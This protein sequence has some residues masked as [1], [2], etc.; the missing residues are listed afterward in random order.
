MLVIIDLQD[1]YMPQFEKQRDKFSLLLEKLS[2][3]IKK[4]KG[5]KETV[6]NLTY[7]EDGFTIPEVLEMGKG[8]GCRH[9]LLKQKFDGSEELH[10]FICEESQECKEI[11]LCGAFEDV[12]VL[13]TWNGLRK[14]GYNVLPVEEDLTIATLDNWR[15]IKKYPDGYLRRGNAKGRL[16][17][18]KGQGA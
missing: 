4:A 18:P 8:Y 15:K 5:R 1:Y 13:D 10:R 6:I 7:R 11:E 9:F 14:L 17:H 16:Y 12:C 2:N 3:R